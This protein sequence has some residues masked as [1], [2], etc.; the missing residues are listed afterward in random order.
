M[1]RKRNP[2]APR[3]S[4]YVGV[5]PSGK[6]HWSYK[7]R[8]PPDPVTGIR[9]W[10]SPGGFLTDY[11]AHRAR[12][13]RLDQI[14]NRINIHPERGTV[15]EY[16]TAWLAGRHDIDPPT[17]A[18]YREAITHSIAP[19]LGHHKLADLDVDHVRAWQ[20]KLLAPG[21]RKCRWCKATGIRHDAPC[22]H[23]SGSGR[24]QV[25]LSPRTV[26]HARVVLVAALTQAVNDG[27]LAR[28]V[29]SLAGGVKQPKQRPTIWN[30]DEISRFLTHVD[31]RDDRAF[32]RLALFSQLRPGE[33][34]A[35]KW[36]NVDLKRGSVHVDDTRTRDD[37][38]QF[39]LG[40]APKTDR[41]DRRIQLPA[42]CIDALRAHRDAQFRERQKRAPTWNDRNLVFPSPSGDIAQPNAINKRLTKICEEAG[43]TRL[44]PHGLRHTGASWMAALG[45]SPRT[46]S[47]R[48]GHTSVTFT[49]DNYVHTHPEAQQA[50]SDRLD[51]AAERLRE[52]S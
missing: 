27:K 51:A 13:R 40:G 19:Y 1:P 24:S 15:A 44:T 33:I 12:E 6:S 52:T 8:L 47:E 35:L 16:L 37:Q 42:S 29:A 34:A 2:D 22:T 32:W 46:I 7:L 17:R 30:E 23:C 26:A 20:A 10:E 18:R 49:L 38:Y 50:A 25:P 5:Y 41:G 14:N 31:Q 21:A 45:E 28:N 11:D 39:V 43:I 9:H 36:S 48:L 4:K 3:K